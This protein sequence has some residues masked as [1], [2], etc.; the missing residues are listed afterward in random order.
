MELTL[1][2][3]FK[4]LLGFDGMDRQSMLIQQAVEEPFQALV[5]ALLV[6]EHLERV[7]SIDWRTS[8]HCIHYKRIGSIEAQGSPTQMTNDK[9]VRISGVTQIDERPSAKE[10]G[11]RSVAVSTKG[12]QGRRSVMKREP[13][14]Q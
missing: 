2:R 8:L 6:L 5:G 3:T 10:Q 1:H 7:Q 11:R 14:K 9:R 12:T 4:G 13:P